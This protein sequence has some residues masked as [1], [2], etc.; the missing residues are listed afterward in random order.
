M[1]SGPRSSRHLTNPEYDAPLARLL[2]L[3]AGRLAGEL[4]ERMVAAGFDDVR[5]SHASVCAHVPPEGIRLTDLADR[6][7]MTNQ[8][9]SELVRDLEALG[10]LRRPDD[11]ADRRARLIAFTDRGWTAVRT[12]LGIFRDIEAEL[13][14][15]IG[16]A[17]MR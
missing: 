3:A 8:A 15:R 1:P 11:P 16:Q 13:A 17:G 2:M 4:R 6:A 9:M 5:P 7:G 10:S 12:A 14:D